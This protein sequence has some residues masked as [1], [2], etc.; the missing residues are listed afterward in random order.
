VQDREKLAGHRRGQ[1]LRVPD[2]G[3]DPQLIAL[4]RDPGQPGDGVDVDEG[5][6]PPFRMISW[7]PRC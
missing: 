5:L 1:Q 3:A 6:G 4:H 2:Q 7:S